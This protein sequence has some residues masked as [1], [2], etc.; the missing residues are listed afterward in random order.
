MVF[1][2]L[3][4]F[5]ASISASQLDTHTIVM[6]A[7]RHRDTEEPDKDLASVLFPFDGPYSLILSLA[8]SY[9]Q[10]ASHYF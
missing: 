3:A 8:P 9:S 7:V 5:L 10:R 6:Q 4:P 1:F 2:V